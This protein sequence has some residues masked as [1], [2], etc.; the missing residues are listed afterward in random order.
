[1]MY[2]NEIILMNVAGS[3]PMRVNRQFTT[4]RK[5]GKVHQNVLVFFKGDPKTIKDNYP[6]LPTF[7][8]ASEEQSVP[9]PEGVELL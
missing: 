2:Y 9:I 8:M 3:M 4:S 7:E 6:V 5:V 1:M